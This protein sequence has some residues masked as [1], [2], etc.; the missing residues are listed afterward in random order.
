MARRA[1]APDL[2]QAVADAL[3]TRLAPD[4]VETP[5]LDAT[6]ALLAQH[7]LRNWTVDDVARLSETGR[8]TLYRRYGSR[9]ALIQMAVTRQ[10]RRFFVAIAATVTAAATPR[11]PDPQPKSLTDMVA[12]GMSEGLRLARRSPLGDLIRRDPAT[13]TALIASAKVLDA[14]TEALAD[15]FLA[16][17][18]GRPEAPDR[19]Q[20]EVVAEA[21]VRL[22]LSFLLIPETG[23]VDAA[24]GTSRRLRTM[25][26]PLVEARRSQPTEQ[27]LQNF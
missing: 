11:S 3:E 22:A 19:Q 5:E 27:L 24:R 26:A 20:A 21:L 4:E 13:G 6:A 8:A 7:G 9:D 15:L 2:Y 12:D 25:V 14:A 17:A 1:P 18:A 23:T 10:A 16:F